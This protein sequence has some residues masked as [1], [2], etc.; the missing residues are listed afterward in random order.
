MRGGG[1][2]RGVDRGTG[3]ETEGRPRGQT[4]ITPHSVSHGAPH[5]VALALLETLLIEALVGVHLAG[6]AAL[7]GA[8]LAEATLT[9]HPEVDKGFGGHRLP[10]QPL[11]LHEAP[12]LR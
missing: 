11:E 6:G 7:A 10:L 5:L 1:G 3:E 4:A 8:D 12:K 2:D 9:Q